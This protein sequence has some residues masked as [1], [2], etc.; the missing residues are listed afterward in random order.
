MIDARPADTFQIAI[1]EEV[2]ADLHE[3]LTRTCWPKSAPRGA[4]RAHGTSV[5]YMKK[6]VA[7]WRDHYYWRVWERRLNQFEKYRV[8]LGAER[9]SV[10]VLVER[11]SRAENGAEPLPIILTHGWPGS[12]IEL[13]ELVEPLAHPERFGG[14]VEDAFTVIVPG[15]PGYGFSAAPSA[16]LSPRHC[17]VKKLASS[18]NC[19]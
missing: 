13:I 2:L 18:I 19:Q 8:P 4:A 3:R 5:D 16:P 7:R 6:V 14:H 11:G 1:D 9:L 17:T 10:H 12:I 15:I